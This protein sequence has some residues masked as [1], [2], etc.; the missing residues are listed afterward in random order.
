MGYFHESGQMRIG[1]SMPNTTDPFRYFIAILVC[2]VVLCTLLIV[3]DANAAPLIQME[4]RWVCTAFPGCW[5]I[6]DSGVGEGTWQWMFFD[7]KVDWWKVQE[8]WHP[9]TD[10]RYETRG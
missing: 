5:F 10:W 1:E 6:P 7:T 9:D 8:L 3:A 4:P 2:I